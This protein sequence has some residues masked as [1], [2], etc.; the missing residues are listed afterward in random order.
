[1]G[2]VLHRC[3]EETQTQLREAMRILSCSELYTPNITRFREND[4]IASGYYDGLIR[5]INQANYGTV[6]RV[7]DFPIF[8]VTPSQPPAE[9]FRCGRFP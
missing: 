2:N 8:S 5:V 7:N 1:M 3:D 4:C 6:I 9:T